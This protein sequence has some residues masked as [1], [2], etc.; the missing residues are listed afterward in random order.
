M[1]VSGAPAT[2]RSGRSR[3]E[4]ECQRHGLRMTGPRRIIAAVLS[5]AHDHPDVEEVHRRAAARDSRIS[6]STVYRTLKLMA[7]KG[8][9]ARHDFGAGRGR[10]EQSGQQHHD[11]LI[12]IETGRVIEFES[13]EIEKLQERIARELGFTLVGHRLE[14]FGKRVDRPTPGRAASDRVSSDRVVSDRARKPKS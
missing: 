8:I 14:L 11:H 2:T 12:D 13:A 7:D 6:L 1:S 5:D 9:L 10:Y 3:L 4:V